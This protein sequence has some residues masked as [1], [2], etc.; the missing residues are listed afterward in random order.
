MFCSKCGKEINDEAV[1]CLFCGCATSNFA[2]TQ[3]QPQSSCSS[4]YLAISNFYAQAKTIRN[5]G[6]AAAILMFGIGIIFSIIVMVKQRSITIPSIIT[7]DQRELA[8][9][10]DAKRK[11]KL[12]KTLACLPVIAL[13]LCLMI[14]SIGWGFAPL[15]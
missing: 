5:L 4:D 7:N 11:F 1:I 12:G 15:L 13:G 9:F 3:A 2:S 8:L 14:A 6:I 10:E